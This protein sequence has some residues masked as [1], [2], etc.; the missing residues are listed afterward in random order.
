MAKKKPGS[1]SKLSDARPNQALDAS[2]GFPIVLSTAARSVANMLVVTIAFGSV[3]VCLF[4]AKRS[5]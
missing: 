5:F 1:K 2:R 3:L 4:A